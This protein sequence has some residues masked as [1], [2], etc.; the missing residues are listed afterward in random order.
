MFRRALVLV[1]L[2]VAAPALHGQ[3]FGVWTNFPGAPTHAYIRIPHSP[4]LNPTGAFTF[5]AWV[6]VRDALG[7]CASIAGKGYQSTWWVG[8]CGTTL[9]S[10]LKG[11][12]SLR[13]G[14]T[15][16]PD[17]WTHI[18]VTFDGSNR[19]HYIDGEL[20][21][22]FAETGPLPTNTSELRIGSDVNF[23]VTARGA[24]NEVRLWNVARSTAQIR[25]AIN[26]PIRSAQPGLVAVW[27]NA[28]TDA[29]GVHTGTIQGSGITG[30]TFPVA[31]NC[32]SSTS[33]ALCLVNRFSITAQ[34]RVGA[35]GTAEGTAQVVN[36]ANGIIRPQAAP[37]S[38][39]A[40]TS[41]SR[42]T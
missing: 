40:R 20:V 29:L 35:P 42:R 10:Y 33:T 19:R 13:D 28:I 3:P 24:L 25:A 7:G 21:S 26:L 39:F 6:N 17:R 14:G 27:P 2:L 22:T 1:A 18:A 38:R 8:V 11:G 12:S 41:P 30:L 15:L 36:A 23:D 5:E 34:F 4:A 31:P 32:G 16:P 9:R 37:A